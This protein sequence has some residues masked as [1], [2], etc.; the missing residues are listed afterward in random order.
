MLRKNRPKGKGVYHEQE[1][2]VHSLC[3]IR[4]A[5]DVKIT[6]RWVRSRMMNLCKREKTGGE[7]FDDYKGFGNS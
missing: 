6:Y 2:K 1:K 3:K 7:S 5:Q 4:R